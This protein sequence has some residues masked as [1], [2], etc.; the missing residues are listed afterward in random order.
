MVKVPEGLPV[1]RVT[2]V[3]AIVEP[4]ELPGVTTTVETPF[5][6][7]T[8]KLLDATPVTPEAGLAAVSVN[9]GGEGEKRPP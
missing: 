3:G 4:G 5:T 6:K 7:A 8:V 9:D 2:V 1:V